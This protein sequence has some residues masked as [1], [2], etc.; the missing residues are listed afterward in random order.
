MTF[1]Q[2]IERE[3]LAARRQMVRDGELLGEGEFRERLRLDASQLARMVAEGNIFTIKVDGVEYFPSLLMAPGI[4]RKRLYS[5]CRL[6]VPAPPSCRLA[7]LSSG[8]TNLGGDSPLEALRDEK[9]YRLLRQ[10]AR[11]YAAEWSRTVVTIYSGRYTEEP[12]DAKPALTA[13]DEVDPRVNLWAR[14]TGALRSG[15][16]I[17]PRGPYAKASAATVFVARHLAGHAE[18]MPE[19]R[20]EVS[21]DNGVAKAFIVRREERGYELDAI[22]VAG[23]DNIVEVVLRIV[24]AAKGRE[25]IVGMK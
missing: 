13:A 17:H 9:Q 8:H 19:A 14:A 25:S 16:Y 20:I 4:D 10:L 12:L 23:A 3:A 15:G 21:V 2:E 6:L 7:Y 18:A 11:A 1:R 24:A 5:I 22:P